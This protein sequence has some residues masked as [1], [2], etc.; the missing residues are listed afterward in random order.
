[1]VIFGEN[2]ITTE[3]FSLHGKELE[4]KRS[5]KY[6]GVRMHQL[7][8]KHRGT[9]DLCPQDYKGKFF[10]D[11]DHDELRCIVDVTHQNGE[12]VAITLRCDENGHCTQRRDR[13]CEYYLNR[14]SDFNKMIR[15]AREHLE[16]DIA[17]TPPC[18]VSAWDLH[19][20]SKNTTLKKQQWLLR[21]M[22]C[23]CGGFSPAVARG[24]I[25]AITEGSTNN[26]AEIWNTARTPWPQLESTCATMHQRVLGCM[27]HTMA[28]AMRAELG[29]T[30]QRGQRDKCS[31]RFLHRIYRMKSDR[32]TWRV[33]N[34]LIDDST[35]ARGAKENWA[36]VTMTEILTRYKLPCPSATMSKYMWKK[37]VNEA[38]NAA[39]TKEL[40]TDKRER[41]KL[42]EYA[43][44]HASVG[45]PRYL[46]QRRS[47]V[48]NNGRS[49]KTKLRCG[50]S[51][52]E[53]ETGRHS[54]TARINR[55]CKCCSSGEVEDSFHFVMKCPR[56][57]NER[58]AMNDEIKS[59]VQ[60]KDY[61]DWIRKK[62]DEKW[63]FLLGDG[64]PVH[65]ETDANLQWGKIETT[66]YHFLTAAYKARREYLKSQ[67][68]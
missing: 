62:P 6:L 59:T 56:F 5:Y 24:L 26:C 53:I 10:Y 60:G 16:V 19:V 4:Q 52:L 64:P 35:R 31:L 45:M 17:N 42:E 37:I 2:G 15:D 3:T 38:V 25:L 44:L 68:D 46:K 8:G 47:W 27:N 12:C 1:M 21:R 58:R 33:M 20:A 22:Q 39:E 67:E 30:S 55:K 65:E 63:A 29:L 54:G 57:R 51:E 28:S 18:D 61:Y 41:S 13:A 32:L 34:C 49:I 23:K 36:R 11:S 7:L 50:T 43:A 40:D 9:R 66:F 14:D 48:M